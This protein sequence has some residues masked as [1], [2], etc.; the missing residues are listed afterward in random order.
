MFRLK[1]CKDAGGRDTLKV[2]SMKMETAKAAVEY[3]HKRDIE[4]AVLHTL[5]SALLM[6]LNEF[7]W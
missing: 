4:F 1:L 5:G 2:I 6:S 3:Q 7:L